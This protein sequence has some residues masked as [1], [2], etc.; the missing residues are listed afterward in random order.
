MIENI[1]A[2]EAF[3]KAEQGYFNLSHYE[4]VLEAAA[5]RLSRSKIVAGLEQVPQAYTGVWAGL[6]RD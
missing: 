1:D 5:A 6:Q 3:A 4:S 2:R